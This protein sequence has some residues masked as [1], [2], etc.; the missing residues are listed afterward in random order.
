MTTVKIAAIQMNSGEDVA[1]NL[2]QGEARPPV[3]RSRWRG[4]GG[5][6]G[7]LRPH[8]QAGI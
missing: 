6:A 2:T 4:T 1:A 7:E 8:G 3:S 5:I